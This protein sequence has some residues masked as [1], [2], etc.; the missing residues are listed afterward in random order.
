MVATIVVVLSAAL[1]LCAAWSAYRLSRDTGQ[2]AW[3]LVSLA[4]VVMAVQRSVTL[5]QA[6]S[7]HHAVVHSGSEF[8]TLVVSGLLLAGLHALRPLLRSVDDADE[9]IRRREEYFGHLIENADAII[10]V[11]DQRGTLVYESPAAAHILGFRRSRV[12]KSFYD[13]L[14]PEDWDAVVE[15]FAASLAHAGEMQALIHRTCD[16]A[17]N[18]R[19][20]E[21]T[22]TTRHGVCGQLVTV[23]N[24]R[25]ITAKLQAD[26]HVTRVGRILD[27]SLNEIFLFDAETFRFEQVNE[28]ARRN[29]GYTL[30]ELMDMAPWDIKPRINRAAFE[31][32][33]RPLRDGS[34][35]RLVFRTVHGRKDG[36]E[37]PVEV[38]L[39]LMDHLRRRVF[40]AIVLDVTERSRAEEE[41]RTLE[42]QL[43]RAQRLESIGTLAG[44]IAHDFNNILTP[45][46]GHLDLAARRLSPRGPTMR[47]LRHAQLAAGRAGELVQ[48][49]LT[50]SRE[51]EQ[52]RQPVGLEALVTETLE[53]LRASIPAT[54]EIR[55]TFA[56][57]EAL[58]LGDPTQLRQ[59]VLNLCTNA[60]HAMRDRGG[61]LELSVDVQGASGRGQQWV[62]LAVRDDGC[63]MDRPTRER[64]FEPFYTTKA[65]RGGSGLG[66]A[67][68]HGIVKGHGGEIEVDSAP[69]E[70]CCVTVRLARAHTATAASTAEPAA[71]P[72]GRGTVLFVDDEPSIAALGGEML[73]SL[74]YRVV[75]VSH[76]A[77]A[78]ERF[79][80]SPNAFAALVTDQTMPG[81]TGC[82]LAR[83]V[84]ALRPELPVLLTTGFS[85][86]LLNE[87]MHELGIR[88]LL[89]KPFGCRELG[90][91]LHAAVAAK[92]ALT[93]KPRPRRAASKTP[94]PSAVQ[95]LHRE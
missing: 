91:M 66:M 9:E 26:A 90:E 84:L 86:A 41:K 94:T 1:L 15:F 68:V 27:R 4:A 7:N 64:M 28:G 20:M 47:H 85:E 56:K 32:L 42:S 80:A 95:S 40:V 74:G 21:S 46:V 48:R 83:E 93:R 88:G 45:I 76:P 16:A 57:E 53:L 81:M 92:T 70:G 35:E 8:A 31:S 49:I 51:V 22:A 18:W 73:R 19:T 11:L 10:A 37:Y 44:G 50:F 60:A 55:T 65:E 38:H 71:A 34:Q 2:R 69:G 82:E 72:R 78:L 89:K 13:F 36:T 39:Q 5:L 24:S 54:V 52:E 77:L 59:V 12:G 29:L 23:V 6:V 62:R 17:G 25:D 67:V 3:F 79:L 75:E 61:T 63:G 43:R 30:D 14:H 87:A 58:V 33:I